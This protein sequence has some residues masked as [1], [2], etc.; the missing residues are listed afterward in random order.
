[1]FVME[2]LPLCEHLSPKHQ[3]GVIEHIVV[4]KGDIEVMVDGV[5]HLVKQGDGFKFKADVP[6][7]YRNLSCE[8]SVFHDVIHY[9]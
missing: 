4:A 1:M 6:H 9:T 3:A 7:G 8:P 5:W 2:L